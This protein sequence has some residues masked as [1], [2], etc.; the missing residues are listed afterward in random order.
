MPTTALTPDT[1]GYTTALLLD[2]VRSGWRIDGA[3]ESRSIPRNG[4]KIVLKASE[5]ELRLRLF[6]YKV[7]SSGRSRSHERRVE[8]TTTYQS[9][10][11]PAPRFADVVIG[12]DEDSGKY[13]GVDSKRMSF[14]GTTHNAS[15]FFD[16]EGLS[17]KPG[18]LLVNPRR[19]SADLFPNS[20]E[21]HAFFD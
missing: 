2:L 15:S 13:V 10:L 14:G 20:M 7:T 1:R 3:P 11:K 8:I 18:E 6:I 16:L 4:V 17:V 9:G 19:A 5:F 21:F 12:I